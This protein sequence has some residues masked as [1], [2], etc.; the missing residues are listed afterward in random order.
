MHPLVWF[1]L[2]VTLIATVTD[3]R[4]RLIPNWLTVS[5]ALIG[6]AAN[7]TL[8]GARGFASALLM[9]AFAAAIFVPVYRMG[10]IG[11]G[12]V[13]LAIALGCVYADFD[14]MAR[15][16]LFTTV[17]AAVFALGLA[18]KR[19]ALS[20]SFKRLVSRAARAQTEAITIAYAP[21]F[22]F[23]AITIAVL[24]LLLR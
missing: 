8:Y 2:L 24:P 22:M 13:K 18:Y 3:L 14:T 23:G 16:L 19:G 1:A 10:G 6:L 20:Q 21:A 15:F 9:A 4:A 7:T 12:D 5:T 11:G 17:S